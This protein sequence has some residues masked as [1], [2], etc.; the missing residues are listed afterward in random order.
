MEKAKG[1]KQAKASCVYFIFCSGEVPAHHTADIRERIGIY[2]YRNHSVV[3]T[4]KEVSPL[5][6]SFSPVLPSRAPLSASFR[7]AAGG[8]PPAGRSMQIPPVQ[9]DAVLFLSAAP[10]L[11]PAQ[12]SA[13]LPKRAG[14][15]R[16]M[17]ASTT[18]MRVPAMA[19][20][21][22]KK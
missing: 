8:F 5:P 13:L 7:S 11:G 20:R 12:R 9:R 21:G 4:T 19:G 10:Q 1:T 18:D 16:P 2:S 22:Y 14:G 17:D 6:D 15:H 3:Q